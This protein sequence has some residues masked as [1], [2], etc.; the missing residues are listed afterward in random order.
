MK[1][2]KLHKQIEVSKEE[3]IEHLKKLIE[4]YENDIGTIRS[5]GQKRIDKIELEIARIENKIKKVEDEG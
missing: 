1:K 3:Y 4:Y 5:R 2:Y